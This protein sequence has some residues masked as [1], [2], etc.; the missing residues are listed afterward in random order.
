[1]PS[2][3]LEIVEL[4]SGEVVLKRVDDESEPLV[5]IKFSDESKAYIN[6]AKLEVAKI[7]MQAGIQAAAHLSGS[8]VR[9]EGPFS[10][11]SNGSSPR[12]I[13]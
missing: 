2:S 5:S 1:M 6:D 7:M 13:H 8:E 4:E 10:E 3:F 11:E 12:I 9:E